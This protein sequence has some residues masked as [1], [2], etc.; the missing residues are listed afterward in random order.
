MFYIYRELS[1]KEIGF[2]L[3]LDKGVYPDFFSKDLL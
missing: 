3:H 1:E 2:V